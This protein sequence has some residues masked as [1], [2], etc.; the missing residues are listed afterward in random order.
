MGTFR[1]ISVVSILAFAACGGGSDAKPDAPVIIIPDA[2]IDAPPDAFEPQFD[3]SCRGNTGPTTAPPTITLSG[4]VNEVVLNGVTPSVQASHAATVDAC[5]NNCVDADKLDTKV[6]PA[7]GCPSTGCAYESGNLSTGGVPLD[8]YLR[9]TKTNNRTTY[10]YPPAP[11]AASLAMIP[12]LSFTNGAF[13]GLSLFLSV[14]QDPAKGMLLVAFLDCANMPISDTA[15][16]TLSI[17]QNGVA[18]QGTTEKDLSALAPQLAGTFGVFN[19]PVGATEVGGSYKGMALR[20]RVVGSFAASS[21]L[22]A[23]RP[24]F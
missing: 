15:N 1:S 14:T 5:K 4:A 19:V 20:A 24:G 13:S 10:V 9:T 2:A 11:I 7:S 3:L 21:T 23:I 18:V 6:T 16:I 12:V 17:K 22:T 8:G